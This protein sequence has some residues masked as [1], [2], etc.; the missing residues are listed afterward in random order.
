[1]NWLADYSAYVEYFPVNFD[2]RLGSHRAKQRLTGHQIV[3]RDRCRIGLEADNTS[4]QAIRQ[5]NF[6]AIGVADDFR[7]KGAGV[8]EPVTCT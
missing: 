6:A 1:M 5:R 2:A 3:K 4:N 8:N 7:D